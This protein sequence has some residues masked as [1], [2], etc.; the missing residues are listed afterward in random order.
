M[1]SVRALNRALG[2][3]AVPLTLAAGTMIDDP[4]MRQRALSALSGLAAI[5]AMPAI[6][7]I[8]QQ[9]GRG[10]I[11]PQRALTDVTHSILP[12]IAY[13]LAKSSI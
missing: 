8:A 4:V 12:L 9:A 5:T 3:A 10:D 7:D 2:Q 1:A 13:G 11:D 6:I